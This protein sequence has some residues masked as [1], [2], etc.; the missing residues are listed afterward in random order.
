MTVFG[1][2]SDST[3]GSVSML[4]ACMVYY[5]CIFYAGFQRA[6]CKVEQ[7]RS[8]Q[9]AVAL[10]RGVFR[11][12]SR[13]KPS[14][15]LCGCLVWSFHWLSQ[16][17]LTQAAPCAVCNSLR[18]TY[19]TASPKTSLQTSLFAP[20]QTVNTL[21]TV[22][23]ASG[24]VPPTHRIRVQARQGA[25]SRRTNTDPGYPSPHLAGVFNGNARIMQW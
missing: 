25:L 22:L 1:Q 13:P 5:A 8:A 17:D 20:S 18:N 2:S 3:P 14:S 21:P 15:V 11:Y 19:A 7:T 4:A 9:L 6:M 12:I 24:R 23:T 16:L 10:R